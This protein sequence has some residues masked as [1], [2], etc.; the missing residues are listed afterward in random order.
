MSTRLSTSCWR[1]S[2]KRCLILFY[3]FVIQS[4]HRFFCNTINCTKKNQLE[5]L[6]KGVFSTFQTCQATGGLWAVETFIGY[7]Q[8]FMR[9]FYCTGLMGNGWQKEKCWKRRDPS[10]EQRET[11]RKRK[12]GPWGSE[13]TWPRG[14]PQLRRCVLLGVDLCKSGLAFTR[15]F[16]IC[17]RLLSCSAIDLSF[18]RPLWLCLSAVRR[19]RV[20]FG[21]R[22]ERR[23]PRPQRKRERSVHPHTHTE[24]ILCTSKI[25]YPRYTASAICTRE[26]LLIRMMSWKTWLVSLF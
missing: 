18:K 5:C 22:R 23:R 13:Q 17:I 19:E 3:L 25:C 26:Q 20:W 10:R 12:Q 15:L 11:R 9:P 6:Y 8:T 7:F 14:Q 21:S 24:M 16:V 2:L 4:Q 1:R